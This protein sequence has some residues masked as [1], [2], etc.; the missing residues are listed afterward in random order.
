AEDGQFDAAV[1]YQTLAL[2]DTP[3]PPSQESRDLL[4]LYK[5][6]RPAS[7]LAKGPPGRLSAGTPKPAPG[8]GGVST[9]KP[10]SEDRQL[11]EGLR[12]RGSGWGCSKSAAPPR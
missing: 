7:D 5:Q 12:R 6:R 8:Y 2:A 10:L 1:R 4:E 11:N 9:P 3:G